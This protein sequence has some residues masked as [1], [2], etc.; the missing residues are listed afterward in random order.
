[1]FGYPAQGGAEFV[2]G[3]APITR[4]LIKEAGLTYIPEDGEIWSARSGELSLHKQF[5]QNNDSLK[6]KL[7]ALTE[8]I[9]IFDFLEQN[10][11]A[12]ADESFKNSIIKMVEGYDAADPKLISTF[13]L[14]D[15]WLSKSEWNDGRIKEG[16]GV[17]I[18]FLETECKKYGVGNLFEHAR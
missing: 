10:F 11:N 8:D 5:I 9:S 4:T 13:T 16:Y 12:E 2:H 1:M 17:L 7:N 15:E 18:K 6:D 3:E 14:R